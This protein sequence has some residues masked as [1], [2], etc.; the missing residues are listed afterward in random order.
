MIPMRRA[1]SH[2]A[3]RRCSRRQWQGRQHRR[4]RRAFT[5]L[6]LPHHQLCPCRRPSRFLTGVLAPLTHRY[7]PPLRLH[8]RAQPAGSL[9]GLRAT[10]VAPLVA[11]RGH[12]GQRA[13][14][15]AA[16]SAMCLLPLTAAAL[17]GQ[18]GMRRSRQVWRH[19][20]PRGC[21][22]CRQDTTRH[23]YIQQGRQ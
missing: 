16:V 23:R 11:R 9:A 10:A 6:L 18:P 5:F 14:R 17:R 4:Y 19:S 21:A 15:C 22:A 7:F 2:R 1:C 13:Y 20:G 3:A 8:Q 12:A